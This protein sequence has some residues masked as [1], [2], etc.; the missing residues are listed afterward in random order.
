MVLFIVSMFFVYM[1]TQPAIYV[2]IFSDLTATSHLPYGY[3]ISNFSC[4][5]LIPLLI[6]NTPYS[7]LPKASYVEQAMTGMLLGDGS[8]VKNYK[9]GGTYF[10]FAQGE[11]HLDYLNHVF[12]LFKNW[13]VVLM[14]APSQ[15]HY[16]I[17]G[18]VHTWYQFSTQSLTFLRPE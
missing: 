17:K 11:T 18:A 1:L 9:R 2:K 7:N 13:G 3:V 12:S 14:D 6:P 15:G 10:K 5:A 8:L 4:T 16:N